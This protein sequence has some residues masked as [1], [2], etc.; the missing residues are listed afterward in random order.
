MDGEVPRNAGLERIRVSSRVSAWRPLARRFLWSQGAALA[1]A[2]AA[3]VVAYF[4]TARV[5][6][7]VVVGGGVLTANLAITHTRCPA[8]LMP[9][10]GL[11]VRAVSP[12]LGI[13]LAGGVLAAF[14]GAPQGTLMPSLV[15][16]WLAT[17]FALLALAPL[18]RGLTLRLGVVG[19][20][21][22][23]RSLAME[24]RMAGLD[25]YQVVGWL[26]AGGRQDPADGDPP[27]LG[28]VD[29]ISRAVEANSLDILVFGVRESGLEEPDRGGVSSISVL[30]RV[31]EA[32]LG[33][34]TRLI[35]ANQ[36]YEELL[37]H[38]PL[39][40]TTSAWFQYVL[41]PRFRT[42]PLAKRAIDVL[43]CVLLLLPAT[44]VMVV[45]AVAIK[46]QDGGPI[47]YR[48]RRVGER[49]RQLDVLKLRTMRV[50]AEGDGQPRWSAPAD[51]RVTAVG[52]LL[53]RSHLD[54]L[55]Q[56]WNVMRGEMS[57]VGPRPERPEFVAALDCTLPYHDWRQSMKPGLTGWAQVRIGYAG[58]D[59]GAAW[60]LAH[61]LYYLKHRSTL[62]DVMILFETLAA[63]IHVAR[64]TLRVP[65]ETL[66]L[67]RAEPPSPS[68]EPVSATHGR[69]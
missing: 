37:G 5:G 66:V 62:L 30:D 20:P 4:D 27:R 25:E 12:M 34:P 13:L 40:M 17:A 43:V 50:D 61:D 18:R 54:E 59:Q 31:S 44:L 10:A 3:G 55:P 64:M 23:T 8:H 28:S 45:A 68:S 42:S 22:L 16:A 38:L 19:S 36:L 7:S 58:S 69:L 14:D 21:Q 63:P 29:A 9:L 1:P 65:D 41:H 24:A 33:T 11:A 49:R 57:L 51:D 60:R 53:R 32:L 52:R 56:L 35:G 26:D 15:A 2:C 39:R 47:L 6:V 67:D 48:Q 46:L